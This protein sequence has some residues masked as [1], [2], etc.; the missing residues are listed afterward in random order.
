MR[1]P[2]ASTLL[3]TCFIAFVFTGCQRARLV[4]V[5]YPVSAVKQCTVADVD[6]GALITCPDGSASFIANGVKGDKGDPG[7]DATEH[8]HCDKHGKCVKCKERH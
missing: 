7:K 2:S 8:F 4:A 6:G 5:N 3:I 1:L